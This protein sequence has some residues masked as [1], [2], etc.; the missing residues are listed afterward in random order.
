[1]FG[2]H[3]LVWIIVTV[4]LVLWSVLFQDRMIVTQVE[5]ERQ[6]VVDTMGRSASTRI[7]ENTNIVYRFCCNWLADFTHMIF[8][9]P[10]EDDFGVYKS[11]K[12][13]HE[14]FWTSIYVSISR[15]FVFAEFFVVT[16]VVAIASFFQ[17][18]SKR[19]ISFVNMAWASPVK[20]HLGIHYA[21]AMIGVVVNYLLW[22]SAVHPYFSALIMLALSYVI[23]QISSNIQPKV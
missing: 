19:S 4:C 12:S 1:M 11:M 5:S 22:P 16:F 17:G 15:V 8:V 14:T 7:Q 6:M 23:Y 2:R 20:Y 13:G 3:I 18:L 10:A 9:P 21:L